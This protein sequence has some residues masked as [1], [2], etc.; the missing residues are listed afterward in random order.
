MTTAFTAS[1]RS[2]GRAPKRGRPRPERR[3]DRGQDRPR[4]PRRRSDR[5]DVTSRTGRSRLPR[6]ADSR[7]ST[8]AGIEKRGGRSTGVTG[9][10]HLSSCVGVP[11]SITEVRVQ[12]IESDEGPQ[13]LEA[14]ATLDE[15]IQQAEP[16]LYQAILALEKAAARPAVGPRG[17]VDAPGVARALD[18]V[19][20]RD[21]GSHRDHRRTTGSTTRSR[22]AARGGPERA[23]S[24]APRPEMQEATS[25]LKD[26]PPDDRRARR[27]RSRRRKTG[28]SACSGCWSST[29]SAAAACSG[30]PTAS[31]RGAATAGAPRP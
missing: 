27:S 12:M 3:R 14:T 9:L 15:V 26:S 6:A 1:P 20:A 13:E 4:S 7:S 23:G 18:E 2:S 25:A 30:R 24:C 28:S 17:G 22:R 31:T 19:E 16:S 10:L 11:P 29:A 5:K 21:R 8:R